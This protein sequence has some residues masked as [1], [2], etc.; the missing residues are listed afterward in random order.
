MNTSMTVGFKERPFICFEKSEGLLTPNLKSRASN[1]WTERTQLIRLTVENKATPTPPSIVL[2]AIK[3]YQVQALMEELRVRL[4]IEPSKDIRIWQ[5]KDDVPLLVTF[6]HAFRTDCRLIVEA[7][8][9]PRP[10]ES[11]LCV[12]V[13]NEKSQTQSE[14]V[15]FLFVNSIS[16][17]EIKQQVLKHFQLNPDEYKEWTL[18]NITYNTKSFFYQDEH[19]LGGKLK[20][21][22]GERFLLDKGAGEGFE[23]LSKQIYAV[24]DIRDLSTPF[25]NADKAMSMEMDGLNTV[26][27]SEEVTT[28]EVDVDIDYDQ[29]RSKIH[30]LEQFKNNVPSFQHLLISW[31]DIAYHRPFSFPCLFS[32]KLT[33]Q[34]KWNNEKTTLLAVEVL[35]EPLPH[36]SQYALFLHIYL[37]RLKPKETNGAENNN[38]STNNN[39]DNNNNNNSNNNGSNSNNSNNN[40]EL[41]FWPPDEHLRILYDEGEQ[42]ITWRRLQAHLATRFKIKPENTYAAL[43]KVRQFRWL[44]LNSS[45]DERHSSLDEPPWSIKGPGRDGDIIVVFESSEYPSFFKKMDKWPTPPLSAKSRFVAATGGYDEGS[46]ATLTDAPK[47]LREQQLRIEVD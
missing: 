27:C 36:I 46:Y 2:K 10:N 12:S 37:A 14:F 6:P 9:Y 25:L 24:T 33:N 42:K 34:K 1:E 43:Y 32:G 17:K 44:E 45:H 8:R 16:V 7:E 23:K 41:E 30:S 39:N 26:Y 20:C 35:P 18:Y 38:T 28:L 47:Q 4:S 11:L 29:L 13:W 22:N 21:S 19:T 40:V 5:V 31:Y 3:P 15:P